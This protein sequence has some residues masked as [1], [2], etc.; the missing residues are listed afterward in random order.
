MDNSHSKWIKDNWF[1]LSTI[2]VL[3]IAVLAIAYVYYQSAVAWPREK[4]ANET[5]QKFLSEQQAKTDKE[6]CLQSASISYSADWSA[7]CEANGKASTCTTLPAYVADK[8]EARKQYNESLCY[9]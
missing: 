5:F 1:K 6:N 7:Q 4:A 2:A 8:V 9:K 3:L